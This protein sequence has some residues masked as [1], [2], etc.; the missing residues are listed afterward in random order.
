MRKH[1]LTIQLPLITAKWLSNYFSPAP[2]PSASQAENELQKTIL[3]TLLTA[4]I[5]GNHEPSNPHS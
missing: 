3:L 1:A 4:A 5:G 2:L